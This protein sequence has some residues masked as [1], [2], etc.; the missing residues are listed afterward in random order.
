MPLSVMD[1]SVLNVSS[2]PPPPPPPPP[3]SVILR[4]SCSRIAATR[5]TIGVVVVLTGV[6]GLEGVEVKATME[7]LL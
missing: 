3:P 1:D 7:R 2:M 4:S 6:G 5:E